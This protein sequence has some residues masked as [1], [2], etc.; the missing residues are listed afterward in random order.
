MKRMLFAAMSIALVFAVP[1][2]DVHAQA[3]PK[4]MTATGTV[5]SV[6]ANS[7]AITAGAKDMTFT[8][9]NTTKVVGKGLTTK[10]G[11]APIVITDA[12]A[13][14]D[15]VRVSYHDM[16]GTMHASTVTVT[17]KAAHK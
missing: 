17:N 2:V 11:G 9:D 16:G 7:L 3:K 13:A 8:I 4:T 6:S 10:T 1:L 14:N 5:K 12:L 15:R